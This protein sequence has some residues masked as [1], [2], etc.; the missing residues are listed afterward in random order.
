MTALATLGVTLGGGDTSLGRSVSLHRGAPGEQVIT[1]VLERF[2]AAA[3]IL[4]LAAEQQGDLD[5]LLQLG[6][7]SA[8]GKLVPIRELVTVSD[9]L[10]ATGTVTGASPPALT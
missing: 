3:L 4:G 6:V 5:T 2:V 1:T 7:R 10:R 8:S 9:A